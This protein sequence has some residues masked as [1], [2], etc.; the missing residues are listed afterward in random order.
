MRILQGVSL[1]SDLHKEMKQAAMDRL[2][3]DYYTRTERETDRGYS[4]SGYLRVDVYIHK[5]K[6]SILVECETRPNIERLIEK[7]LKRKKLTYRNNYLLIVPT[8]EYNRNEWG[9]L[10][11]YY[12]QIYAYSDARLRLMCDYR[13]LGILQD[14]VV[15]LTAYVMEIMWLRRLK[16]RIHE[17]RSIMWDPKTCPRCMLKKP[18]RGVSCY[19]VYCP[20]HNRRWVELPG[21]GRYIYHPH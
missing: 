1:E 15:S 6:M 5:G 17:L 7:A 13:R 9:R 11:G 14:I 19:E 21:F 3:G 16:T 20:L 2:S 8:S 18:I 4:D 10:R 12:D